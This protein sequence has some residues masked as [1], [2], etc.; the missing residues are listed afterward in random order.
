MQ[1]EWISSFQQ[2]PPER[3]DR[4]PRP[5]E[6]SEKSI[7]IDRGPDLPGHYGR[8]MIVLLVRDPECLF[9][10]WELAGGKCEQAVGEL[11][12]AGRVSQWILRV[13]DHTA[14]QETSIP[15][16]REAGNWYIHARPDCRYHVCI[17]LQMADGSFHAFVCSNEIVTPRKGISPVVDQ[18][19]LPTREEEEVIANAHQR[20]LPQQYERKYPEAS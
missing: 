9:A 7:Y 4:V 15:V 3:E 12:D 5:P 1:Y 19:W 16:T 13:Y 6:V 17:G 11:G 18:D 2:I 20:G 8:D 14:N 10:Y